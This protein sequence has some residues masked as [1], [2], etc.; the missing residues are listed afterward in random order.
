MPI[1]PEMPTNRPDHFP[2]ALAPYAHIESDG[3][4]GTT[5]TIDSHCGTHV[6]APSH[7]VAG[8]IGVDQIPLEVLV[9]P[10]QRVG[11][12]TAVVTATH[13]A[14]VT[15]ERVVV[16]TGWS[17]RTDSPE[18]ITSATHLVAE[19]ALHLVRCGVRLVGIDAPSVDAPGRDDVHH[20]LLSNGVIIVENLANTGALPEHFELIVSPLRIVDGD[21]SPARVLAAVPQAPR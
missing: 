14:S 16:H 11:V 18:Y 21:G 5:I 13:L 1:S 3:W 20:I 12:D 6:D 15:A 17:D 10:A 4:A 7:F 8:A 2:P 19:A 9:G